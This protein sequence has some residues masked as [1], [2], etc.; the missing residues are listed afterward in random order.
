MSSATDCS[1]DP[2]AVDFLVYS[3]V[4]VFQRTGAFNNVVDPFLGLL[5]QV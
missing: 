5:S 2:E 4:L 3:P 1:S